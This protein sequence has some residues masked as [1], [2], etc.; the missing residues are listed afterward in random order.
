MQI[1]NKCNNVNLK[2]MKKL[3]SLF[4]VVATIIFMINPNKA[5][6]AGN[7]D[8]NNGS[9]IDIFDFNILISQF[10]TTPS[11]PPLHPH[12]VAEFGLRKVK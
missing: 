1:K 7:A 5:L 9:K 4:F 8:L 2:Y 10:N 12:W 3:Y 6:S 11:T